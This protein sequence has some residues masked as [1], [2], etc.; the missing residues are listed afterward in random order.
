MNWLEV[1]YS[2]AWA[3]VLS[4]SHRVRV[5]QCLNL[6]TSQ[7]RTGVIFVAELRKETRCITRDS[8]PLLAHDEEHDDSQDGHNDTD[9]DIAALGTLG[10]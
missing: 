4:A 8:C 6:L 3:A 1:S 7:R 2:F 5:S 9:S 10:A